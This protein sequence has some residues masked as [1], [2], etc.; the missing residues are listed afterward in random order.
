MAVTDPTRVRTTV[1]VDREVYATFVQMA[2][3]SGMSV[4]KC[5]GEWLADTAD[6]AQFVAQKMKEARAAPMLVMREMQSMALGLGDAVAA[7]IEAIRKGAAVWRWGR[8]V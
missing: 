1:N 6:G 4:S 7:D 3:L 8:P 2:G 5:I